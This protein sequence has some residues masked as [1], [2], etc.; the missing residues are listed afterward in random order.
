MLIIAHRF[1]KKEH[2]LSKAC[3]F[4][5]SQNYIY[6]ILQMDFRLY[7]RLHIFAK[8]SYLLSLL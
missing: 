2:T 7:A 8:I 3:F 5:N 6:V 4:N 1:K